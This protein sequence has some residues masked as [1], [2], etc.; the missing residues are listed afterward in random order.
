MTF[1]EFFYYSSK[2]RQEEE[3][4]WQHTSHLMW[5]TAKVNAGKDFRLSPDD[6]N[7]YSKQGKAAGDAVKNEED[8]ISLR[9]RI[10]AR[11][12]QNNTTTT[13]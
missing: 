2:A 3:R 7:P 10:M 11:N 13:E 6:F 1:R 9:D 5:L 4:N 12:S 8:V